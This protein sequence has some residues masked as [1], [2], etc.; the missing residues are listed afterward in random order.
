[1][2]QLARLCVG[3]GSGGAVCWTDKKKMLV[4]APALGWPS[5]CSTGGSCMLEASATELR[6]S[7]LKWLQNRDPPCEPLL[8]LT[9]R[10]R[11]SAT[12][13][14]LPFCLAQKG[15]PGLAPSPLT[16]TMP[17]TERNQGCSPPKPFP[18]HS[19]SPCPA[20]NEGNLG[21]SHPYTPPPC[22]HTLCHSTCCIRGQA[23]LLLP[24]HLHPAHTHV[25]MCCTGGQAGRKA[26]AGSQALLSGKTQG[27]CATSAAAA[28][29]GSYGG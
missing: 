19:L 25:A 1:M 29:D 2:L 16:F 6:W 28:E 27:Q 21:C 7:E 10:P 17:C 9:C 26:P 20:Q 3:Y 13:S 11:F 4:C 12:C 23:G 22:P 14:P 8:A 15:G 5:L 18:P 24:S